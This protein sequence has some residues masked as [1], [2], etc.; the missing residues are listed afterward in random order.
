V[1]TFVL[2]A[3]VVTAVVAFVRSVLA[4]RTAQ[5]ALHGTEPVVGSIDTWPTVPRR[6]TE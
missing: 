5:R 6:P 3:A 2:R 1:L 4:G